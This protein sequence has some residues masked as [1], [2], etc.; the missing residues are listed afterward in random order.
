MRRLEWPHCWKLPYRPRRF[1]GKPVKTKLR[2][3]SKTV[4]A[5]AKADSLGKRVLN[6][7]QNKA[8]KA[9]NKPKKPPLPTKNSGISQPKRG[10]SSIK[11]LAIQK[12]RRRNGQNRTSSR[13]ETIFGRRSA[14]QHNQ[15][16]AERYY[17]KRQQVIGRQRARTG[18]RG[19]NATILG[20]VMPACRAF[21][22]SVAEGVV[23]IMIFLMRLGSGSRI[24]NRIR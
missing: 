24:L 17:Q 16:A 18:S 6:R 13:A 7:L 3:H 5:A 9:V 23:I 8:G 4:H 2:N 22:S 21:Y 1:H 14:A 15:Q 11:A 20:C 10:R 19:A 12:N